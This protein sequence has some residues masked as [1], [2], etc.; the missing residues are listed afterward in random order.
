MAVLDQSGPAMT[1]SIRLVTYDCPSETRDG[2]MLADLAVWHDPA[3][4]RQRPVLGRRQEM[5]DS[6]DV[7]ALAVG[8]DVAEAG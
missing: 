7:A 1:A 2:R 4:R 5:I 3:D 8:L 6:L